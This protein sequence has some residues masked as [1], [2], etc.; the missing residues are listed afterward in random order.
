METKQIKKRKPDK[1]RE[2]RTKYAII[3]KDNKIGISKKYNK[4]QD[5][6]MVGQTRHKVQTKR[7]DK[8][9]RH[10]SRERHQTIKITHS[11]PHT[12]KYN[13][14]SYIQ[15]TNHNCKSYV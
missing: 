12:L 8:V 6:A 15:S 5:I 3:G 1:N 9:Q 7:G 2:I 4:H 10:V 14:C 11:W 13:M